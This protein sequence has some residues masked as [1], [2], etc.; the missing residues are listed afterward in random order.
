MT[1]A[2]NK[3]PDISAEHYEWIGR[4]IVTWAVIEKYIGDMLWEVATGHSFSE[5]TPDASISLAFVAGMDPRTVIG[6]L[7]AVVRARFVKDA[8]EFDKLA[9]DLDGLCR[10]RAIIAHGRWRPGKRPNTME[11]VSFKAIGEL[12]ISINAYT[13]KELKILRQNMLTSVRAL[14][15]FLKERGYSKKNVNVA[16]A[17][18]A[19]ELDRIPVHKATKQNDP[20]NGDK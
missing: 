15:K 12:K 5:M 16:A 9:D 19:S 6:M 11:T 2:N 10:K 8:D 3:M 14:G 17:K 20:P 4:V 1:N 13:P 7:K 18:A